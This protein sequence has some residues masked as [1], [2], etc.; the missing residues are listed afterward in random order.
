MFA[1]S[2]ST[3]LRGPLRTASVVLLRERVSTLS[4]GCSKYAGALLA[5]APT[6]PEVKVQNTNSDSERSRAVQHR[7]QDA[8]NVAV[9]DEAL[10]KSQKMEAQLTQEQTQVGVAAGSPSNEPAAIAA[11]ETQ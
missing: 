5:R 6:T 3:L 7:Q 11:N 8:G 1:F 2:R 9:V 4:R 10:K